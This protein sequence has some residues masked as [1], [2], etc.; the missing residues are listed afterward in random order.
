MRGK[1][2]TAAN[3][4]VS[5]PEI[6][7]T[8]CVDGVA[9]LELAHLPNSPH[10]SPLFLSDE[11]PVIDPALRARECPGSPLVTPAPS[12]TATADEQLEPDVISPS[13]REQK[14]NRYSSYLGDSGYMQMFSDESS[15]PVP[16]EQLGV[17]KVDYTP[18]GLQEGHLDVF[19]EYAYTWCPILDRET[20]EANPSL[21]QSPLLQHALALCADQIRPSL[22]HRSSPVEHYKRAKELFYGNHEANP[23]IRVMAL[24]L[25]Y[26]WSCDTPDVVS[27]DN[28][29]WW[30]GTAIRVAQQIGLHWEISGSH[31]LLADDSLGIRRR[32]WWI[33]VVSLSPAT[34]QEGGRGVG[35]CGV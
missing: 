4:G 15:N 32:I 9:N 26:W 33:L 28:T 6:A 14:C 7:S 35:V 10:R 3:Q 22:L 30:T 25:L 5:Q 16:E 29:A 11:T 20:L 24:M 34:V 17:Q 12:E 31:S 8:D 2:R 13:R 19:F 21:R 1:R 23:L 18:V 27:L